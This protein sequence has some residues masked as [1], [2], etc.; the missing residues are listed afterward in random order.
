MAKQHLMHPPTFEL[1]FAPMV[2]KTDSGKSYILVVM[3]TER[4][5]EKKGS[6]EVGKKTW[7]LSDF[8]CHTLPTF[9]RMQHVGTYQTA[10]FLFRSNARFYVPSYPYLQ[11]P[12]FAQ[13][14]WSSQKL[15]LLRIHKKEVL[16]S[17]E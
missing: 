16:P 7:V 15:G 9:V 10:E 3:H 4:K 5:V 12:L 14:A 17:V 13:Y 2:V 1:S 6:A 11:C 8:M